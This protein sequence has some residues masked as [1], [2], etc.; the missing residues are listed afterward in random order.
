MSSYRVY[1][2][3]GAGSIELPDLIEAADDADALRQAQQLKMDAR[4]CEVWQDQRLVG[5]LENQRFG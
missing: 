3:D 5:T 1:S 4:K 2:L